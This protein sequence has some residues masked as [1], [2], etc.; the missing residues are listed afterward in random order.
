LGDRRFQTA[1]LTNPQQNLKL[2]SLYLKDMIDRFGGRVERA[3]AAY[4]AGPTRVARWTSGTRVIPAEEFIE[5]I[6]FAETRTYVMNVISHREQYR[7]LY[8]LPVRPQPGLPLAVVLA[9]LAPPEAPGEAP[10]VK[11]APAKKAASA[12]KKSRTRSR[13]T[14][15]AARKKA[16]ARKPARAP[17]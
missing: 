1:Q 14:A 15:V 10:A 13:T 4:N 9:A 5:S 12:R 16:P 8:S 7:R 6:P 11:K 17:R 2:G 3:L